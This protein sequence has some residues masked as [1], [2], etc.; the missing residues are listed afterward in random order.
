MH[1]AVDCPGLTLEELCTL[2]NL[3]NR[4]Y[5][6]DLRNNKVRIRE[7]HKIAFKYHLSMA[8]VTPE[9]DKNKNMVS[10]KSDVDY[11]KAICTELLSHIVKETC[12]TLG[13]RQKFEKYELKFTR[14]YRQ[15][16]YQELY[17]MYLVYYEENGYAS[18]GFKNFRR[19]EPFFVLKADARAQVTGACGDCFEISQYKKAT[20]TITEQ[21]ISSSTFVRQA[22]EYVVDLKEDQSKAKFRISY[23]TLNE[24]RKAIH[25]S[26]DLLAPEIAARLEQKQDKFKKHIELL[27]H[28]KKNRDTIKSNVL[29]DKNSVFITQDY[30]EKMS[31]M[32]WIENQ[33]MYMRRGTC[34]LHGSIFYWG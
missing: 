28:F 6:S 5:T 10:L 21:K 15:Y 24:D 17:D 12:L 14:F 9:K 31:V 7:S 3:G 23:F 25:K 11:Q 22:D 8:K 34:T 33:Q 19:A 20:E 30:S 26:E 13:E 18:L 29:N 2:P 32:S 16:I 4:N 27:G 1:V